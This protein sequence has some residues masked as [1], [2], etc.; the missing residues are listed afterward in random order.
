MILSVSSLQWD[1]KQERAL[2]QALSAQQ[3]FHLTYLEGQERRRDPC[4]IRKITT[5][6]LAFQNTDICP[7][8]DRAADLVNA[9]GVALLG[10]GTGIP[11]QESPSVTSW[12]LS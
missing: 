4:D 10:V 9:A 1:P 3:P 6:T 11:G 12:V 8:Q 5:Q 7:L 2:P